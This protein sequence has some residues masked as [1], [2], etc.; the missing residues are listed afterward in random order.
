MPRQNVAISDGSLRALAEQFADYGKQY[1][2]LAREFKSAKVK[3]GAISVAHQASV[4]A[5]LEGA[6]K[7]LREA[8]AKLEDYLHDQRG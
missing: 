4:D 3:K 6:R 7:Q 2:E 8:R 1:L 5:G